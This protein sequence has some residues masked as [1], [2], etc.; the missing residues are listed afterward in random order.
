[1]TTVTE[2]NRKGGTARNRLEEARSEAVGRRTE[3]GFEALSN[4]VSELK[5]A[6]PSWSKRGGVYPAVVR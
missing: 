6:K 5:V 1:L 3:I 4:R 2:V